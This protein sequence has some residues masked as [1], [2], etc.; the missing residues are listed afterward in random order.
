MLILLPKL[1]EVRVVRPISYGQLV[2][3][4]TRVN[5]L[6]GVVFDIVGTRRRRDR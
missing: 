2:F 1:R 4:V 3:R 5:A 6:A